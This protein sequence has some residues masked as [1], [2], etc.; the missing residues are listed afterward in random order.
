MVKS[1]VNGV[2][3]YY[4]SAQYQQEVSGSTTT[5]QKTYVFDSLTVAV[6]TVTPVKA[7]GAGWQPERTQLG[8]DG[9]DQFYNGNSDRYGGFE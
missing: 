7:T 9:S 4:P 8:H 2:T 6:R 1:V 3:T 5:I